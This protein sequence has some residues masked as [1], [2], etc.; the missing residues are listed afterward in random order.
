MTS[1]HEEPP[2]QLETFRPRKKLSTADAADQLEETSEE[3]PNYTDEH[4]ERLRDPVTSE[5]EARGD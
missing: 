4:P 5:R 3:K 2:V 1:H